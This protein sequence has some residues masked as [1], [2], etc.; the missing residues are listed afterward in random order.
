MNKI[1]EVVKWPDP[2]LA[3]PGE[4]VTVFDAKLKKLVEEMFESGELQAALGID[5]TGG[6]AS[7]PVAEPEPVAAAPLSIENRL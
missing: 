2:V 3:K 5:D 7:E 6:V 1:H 4:A